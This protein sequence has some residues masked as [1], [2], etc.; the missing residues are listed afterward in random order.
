MAQST[1][2]DKYEAERKRLEGHGIV[3]TYQQVRNAMILA[4]AGIVHA[5]GSTSLDLKD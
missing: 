2:T 5:C 1:I 3:K 4:N